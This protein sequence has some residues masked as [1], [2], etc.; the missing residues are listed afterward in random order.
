MKRALPS[1]L[2]VALPALAAEYVSELKVEPTPDATS[3]MVIGVEPASKE[4]IGDMPA[5][6]AAGDRVYDGSFRLSRDSPREIRVLLVE[7]AQGAPFL[8]ADADVDGKLSPEERFPLTGDVVLKLP[9]VQPGQPPFPVL[10]RRFDRPPLPDGTH[11][12]LRS[13]TAALEGT[14]E[15]G[16]MEMLVR[17]PLDPKTGQVDLKGRIGMDLDED[18]VIETALSAG[19]VKGDVGDGPR[20]FRHYNSYISTASFDSATGKIVLRTHPASDYKEFDLRPGTE[21]EDFAF[22]DLEGRQRRFSELRGKVVLLDFWSTTCGPCIAEMPVLRK[23]QQEQGS[24]GF[25]ILGMDLD[26]D[27]ET[28]RKSVGELDLPWMHA[29]SASVQDVILKRFGVTVFP[30]HI[31]V[32]REGRI[33]SVGD[34]GQPPLKKDQLAATVEEVVS[35]KPVVEYAGK[36]AGEPVPRSG[37]SGVRLAAATPELLAALPAPPAPDE[38]VHAGEMKLFRH[39]D[40]KA[41]VALVERPEGKPFLYVDADLDGKLSAGERF[42]LGD[43]PGIKEGWSAAVVRFPLTTGSVRVYP[44]LLSWSPESRPKSEEKPYYLL[45]SMTA[46]V[47]GTVPVE[48][49]E[50]RVR[51]TLSR[52]TPE[53]ELRAGEMAMDL[54][55]DGQF[56]RALA[57][58]ETR[59]G[60]GGPEPV[61]FRLGDLYLSTRSVDPATGKIVL[62]THAPSEYQRFDLH[63]GSQ[64]PDFEYTDLEGK[65]RRLS[66]LRGKVVLLDFWG[67][68][69]GSCVEEMP[70]L[71]KA[72]AA[73][74]DRGLEI[75]G[76]DYGDR[77]DQQRKFL[78]EKKL[79]WLHATASSVQEVTSKGFE[80]W[81]FPTKILLDREGRV[82]AV[83]D[84]DQTEEEL[85][86]MLADYFASP[87]SSR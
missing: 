61:I 64:V 5:P 79:P 56:S 57:T 37:G 12:L 10:L 29:T 62:R 59:M 9:P 16:L 24:R 54:D 85:M 7:P 72:Y 23:I 49:R 21:L 19:E 86:K 78:E 76:M 74:R 70:G 8:Y 26:D 42:E 14:I 71:Q 30:T 13:R 45:R 43:W 6:P 50:V 75:L 63:S 51:Y 36:L 81:R 17:Y 40:L 27:L 53:V 25:V 15:I 11:R 32:D 58:R 80:V 82:L 41:Q 22:T 34:P 69:C 47:E 83:V 48:G 33:I 67:A 52:E 46:F 35:R 39:L 28:H 73:F 44:V 84:E 66:E 77:L 60:S 20:I 18:G 55:G 68:W 4:R 87:T 31:L 1:L 38:K 3:L 65:T 2:L